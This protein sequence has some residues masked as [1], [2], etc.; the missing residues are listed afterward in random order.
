MDIYRTP[1]HWMDRNIKSK[2]IRSNCFHCRIIKR[3]F[4]TFQQRLSKQ[5]FHKVFIRREP[6][7]L[8][9]PFRKFSSSPPVH[10]MMNPIFASFYEIR[11]DSNLQVICNKAVINLTRINLDFYPNQQNN[12]IK[13]MYQLI[14]F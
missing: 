1:S 6:I 2:V 8:F 3:Y 7:V 4:E 10:C 14:F 5:S 12:V 13:N 9:I 11:F